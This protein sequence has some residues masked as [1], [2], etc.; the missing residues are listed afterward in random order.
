MA[1]GKNHLPPTFPNRKLEAGQAETPSCREVQWPAQGGPVTLWDIIKS[2]C[3]NDR[4]RLKPLKGEESRAFGLGPHGFSPS[5]QA[6]TNKK[7]MGR[8]HRSV[9]STPQAPY[10]RPLQG[11]GWTQSTLGRT[12]TECT[13]LHFSEKLPSNW[14]WDPRGEEKPQWIKQF[15]S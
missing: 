12:S 6:T 10:R 8:V 4:V 7:P 15:C 1:Q 9:G 2:H 13:V 3:S 14:Q 11:W 5:H